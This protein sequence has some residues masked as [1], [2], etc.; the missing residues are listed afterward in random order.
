LLDVE[1]F[2]RRHPD[3]T[4]QMSARTLAQAG[5]TEGSWVELRTPHSDA[6]VRLK[7]EVA[8]MLDGIVSAEYGWWFPEDI[9]GEP[10]LSGT[11]RSNINVLTSCAIADCEPLVG[12]WL[13]NGIPCKID[14]VVNPARRS[15]KRSAKI[16]ST[17]QEG[18]LP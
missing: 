18:V 8:D 11:W 3:P 14:P 10:G 16:H 4:V 9:A 5:L 13:Y 15:A 6:S 12:T 2:R 1:E 7:A 17:S